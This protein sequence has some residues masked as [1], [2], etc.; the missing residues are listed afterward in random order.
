ME[1][2]KK[3]LERWEEFGKLSRECWKEVKSLDLP[4]KEAFAKYWSCMSEKGAHLLTT[5]E[6]IE[7]GVEPH[8]ICVLAKVAKGISEE[9]AREACRREGKFH[10]ISLLAAELRKEME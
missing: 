2:P 4:T 5:K 8:P 9:S 1:V 3:L 7:A 6:A 10:G